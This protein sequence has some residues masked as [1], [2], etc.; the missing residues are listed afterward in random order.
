[1]T[2]GTGFIAGWCIVQLLERGYAVRATI[3]NAAREADVRAAAARAGAT[4]RL[5]FAIADLTKDEGWDEAMAGVDY[6]LHIASPLGAAAQLS[7]DAFVA[8]ARDGTLRVLRAA[9]NAGVQRVVMTSAAAAARSPES[10][11]GVSD[12]TQWADPARSKLDDYRYSKVLAERA[13]WEF[14][15]ANDAGDT[16][17]TVLPGAV[18]GPLLGQQESGSVLLIKRLFDGRPSTLP[19]LSLSVVD[20]RDLADLHIRAMT[21]PAAAGERFIGVG[22]ALWMKDIAK[23][24]RARFGKRAAKVP[25]CVAPDAAVRLAALKNSQLKLVAKDLG[26]RN[27]MSSE[28]ARRLL[29]FNP[30]PAAE[31]LADC[32]ETLLAA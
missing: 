23:L 14:M 31:T 26:K 8:A 2:G 32:A 15:R 9:L 5:S 6:V 12:E 7:R 17:T 27:L 30:R 20:V 13:A 25:I 19:R 18:F 11:D 24:L 29:G 22:E 16:L 4:D 1:M 28:K 21:S 3:R 10:A